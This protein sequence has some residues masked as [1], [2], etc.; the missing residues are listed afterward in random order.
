M[1][2]F[3][4]L[5]GPQESVTQAALAVEAYKQAIR[6]KPDYVEAHIGLGQS[7]C[8]LKR[9]EE[10]ISAFAVAIRQNPEA[11]D[12]Y[13]GLG[14]TYTEMERYP[15]AVIERTRKL[16]YAYCYLGLLY[17]DFGNKA[18][19]LEQ[20]KAIKTLRDCDLCDAL[21]NDLFNEI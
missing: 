1:N 17:T 10:A 4:A 6:L 21:A 11:E 12:A 9:Y 14:S 3:S 13:F 2:L 20:Y 15:E 7:Y 18:S 19:A 5:V 16:A 8:S